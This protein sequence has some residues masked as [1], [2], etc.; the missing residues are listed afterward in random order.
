MET[1]NT[2]TRFA[3]DTNF[4]FALSEESDSA[5]GVRELLLEKKITLLVSPT[6]IQEV[7]YT[8][9]KKTVQSRLATKA[10]ASIRTW[11]ITPFNL[12]SV[13]QHGEVAL[14]TRRLIAAG[15]VPEGEINDGQILA[16]AA[17]GG[18]SLLITSD[19][20]I[21]DIDETKLARIFSEAN[22]SAVKPCHPAVVA[23]WN[24]P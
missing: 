21:L 24:K 11:V 1:Y 15:L 6:V 8:A 17:L 10:L 23:R 22:L 18:A 7:A 20:H 5:H 3:L 14:F 4:L 16:E 2:N 19:H 9:C 12:G 13:E